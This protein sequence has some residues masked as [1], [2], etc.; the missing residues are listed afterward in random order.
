MSAGRD[1]DAVIACLATA[2]LLVAYA[3]WIMHG[4]ATGRWFPPCGPNDINTITHARPVSCAPH[5]GG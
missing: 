1:R 4:R 3:L 2:L 5:H